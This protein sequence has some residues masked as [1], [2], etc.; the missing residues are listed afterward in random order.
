MRGLQSVLAGL[1]GGQCITMV[2]RPTGL[3]PETWAERTAA[4]ECAPPQAGGL[5]MRSRIA[6]MNTDRSDLMTH[7]MQMPCESVVDGCRLRGVRSMGTLIK[8]GKVVSA[9]GTKRRRCV[10]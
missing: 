5:T 8:G 3:A 2:E 10:D 1:P 6:R 9:A 4:A 7:E